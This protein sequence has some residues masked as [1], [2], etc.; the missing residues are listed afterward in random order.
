MPRLVVGPISLVH[1]M[2]RA[3]LGVPHAGLAD[4]FVHLQASLVHALERLCGALR[5][6]A[7]ACRGP[8]LPHG[9]R[10]QLSELFETALGRGPGAFGSLAP[11]VRDLDAGCRP[12]RRLSLCRE[13]LFAIAL[14]VRRVRQLVRQRLLHGVESLHHGPVQLHPHLPPLDLFSCIRRLVACRVTMPA[15]SRDPPPVGSHRA[16]LSFGQLHQ[17]LLHSQRRCPA[18]AH[19]V[20]DAT[21]SALA[22]HDVHALLAFW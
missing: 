11:R 14:A 16:C 9:L 1:A 5:V 22:L 12:L 2:L 8:A 13:L 21:E 20:L 17:Q 18:S 19:S 3:L 10:D 4:Q 7:F 6:P 15:S